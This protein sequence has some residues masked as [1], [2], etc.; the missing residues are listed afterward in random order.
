[1][2]CPQWQPMQVKTTVS[3]KVALQKFKGKCMTTSST[4]N[5]I[6]FQLTS[7][8]LWKCVN[9]YW[10]W[11]CPI[12]VGSWTVQHGHVTASAAG[13]PIQ[14]NHIASW[15]LQSH[16]DAQV[17]ASRIPYQWLVKYEWTHCALFTTITAR[18]DSKRVD[19]G[20]L[21]RTGLQQNTKHF[22]W[23]TYF[24]SQGKYLCRSMHKTGPPVVTLLMLKEIL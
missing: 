9:I 12:R 18:N 16:Q 5:Y 21:L 23:M 6:K 8:L 20:I 7:S 1:M 13:H 4:M 10:Q 24:V 17:T 15:T 22:T 3:V 19:F 11:L 14:W 2:P